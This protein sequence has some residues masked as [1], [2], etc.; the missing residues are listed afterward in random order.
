MILYAIENYLA[1]SDVAA[2]SSSS[3][4]ALYVRE[5]LYNE[6]PSK[7]F[8]FTGI[9]IVANP[10][11]VCVEFDAPKRVTFAAIF[12]H[13]LI[14][15]GVGSELSL[16]G[17]DTGC[18]DSATDW[19][20]PD[21][22][23]DISGRV[24]ADWNDLYATLDQT[25]LAFRVDV[26]DPAN[27]DGY[28]ELGELFLGQYGALSSAR[29]SPGRA[30]S[31]RLFRSFN[32]TYYGQYW[33]E[34]LSSSLTMELR[35]ANLGDPRQVDSLRTLVLAI[36]AAGSRFVVVPN[37][38]QSFVYYVALENESGFMEQI[39]RGIECEA[40]FWTLSLRTLTK[41]IALL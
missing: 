40:A 7:P 17:S 6:R 2:L 24:V 9:G 36:H 38:R 39:A 18:D 29:L 10:E 23:L 30:E 14:L 31:P 33:I 26:I 1:G 37:D 19:D 15:T 20:V 4:D 12:N 28:G 21:Y 16:K 22:E 5:N 41:G 34:P 35:I 11:W 3:E 27:A 8:R 32:E 13:N 25:R